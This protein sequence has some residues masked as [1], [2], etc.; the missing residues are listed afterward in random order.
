MD[1]E[2]GDLTNVSADGSNWV[3]GQSL[4]MWPHLWAMTTLSLGYRPF[5]VS[6]PALR[7]SLEA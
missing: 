7:C 6:P 3:I 5:P 1:W 4:K 2:P